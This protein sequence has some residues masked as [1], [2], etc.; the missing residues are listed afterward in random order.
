MIP[1]KPEHKGFK[2]RKPW[3]RKPQ[4]LMRRPTVRKPGAKV[5]PR[6]PLRQIGKNQLGID[7]R[8]WNA[9]WKAEFKHIDHCE[10]C[11]RP[12]GPGESKLTQMH[13]L[14]QRFITT[15][16]G[17]YRAA[18]VCWGEHR[19]YDEATG[20]DV[21][22]RMAAFVDGLIERRSDYALR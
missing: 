4:T 16:E 5:K 17:C 19:P 13:G 12:D 2:P 20:P 8:R 11:G 7:K 9:E 6:K 18:K 15:R 10:S 1:H 21:H 14:K 22:E 3:T